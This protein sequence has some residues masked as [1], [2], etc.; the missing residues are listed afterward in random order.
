MSQSTTLPADAGFSDVPGIDPRNLIWA[1]VALAV[2]VVVIRIDNP[3]ALNFTH[4]MCGVLWTGIDLFMGFVVG[5][6]MRSLPPP[7]R[8]AMILRLMPKTLFLLPTLSII[9]GTTGWFHARELGLLDFPWPEYGWVLA[10]LIIVG[11]LTVQGLGVLLP[12]NLLVYFEMRKP[13]PDGARIGR[14]M[15]R[16]VYAVALQGAMQVAIIVVMARFVTGV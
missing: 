13:V 12:T 3:W 5:P 15:K 16:Y 9:T 14:L 6:I 2:M 8:R 1:G 7:A 10:A 11:I 4:V